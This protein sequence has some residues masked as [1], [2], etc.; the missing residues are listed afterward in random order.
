MWIGG[1][2]VDAESAKTFAA[3]NPATEEEVARIPQ[4]GEPDM[5]R[6]IDAARKAF[7][8]WSRKTQSERSECLRQL[9]GTLKRHAEELARLET[10]HRG[11]P[12]RKSLLGVRAAADS[13]LETSREA[14]ASMEGVLDAKPWESA[15]SWRRG[16]SLSAWS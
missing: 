4:A 6:A 8:V 12:I 16:T 11:T 14:L 5:E 3:T 10:M 15:L 7:P 2:W 1:K 9:S 13:L